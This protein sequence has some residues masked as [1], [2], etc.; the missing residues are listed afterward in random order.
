MIN[1]AAKSQNFTFQMNDSTTH[2]NGFVQSVQVCVTFEHTL[3]R[4]KVKV[5]KFPTFDETEKRQSMEI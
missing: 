5:S 4:V 1:K 2:C 3:K